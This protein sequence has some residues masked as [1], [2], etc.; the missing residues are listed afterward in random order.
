VTCEYC[1]YA[2]AGG[3]YRAFACRTAVSDADEH[4]DGTR[5]SVRAS[6]VQPAEGVNRLEVDGGT[7]AR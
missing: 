3:F 6:T 2:T 5:R 4:T 1:R 7:L